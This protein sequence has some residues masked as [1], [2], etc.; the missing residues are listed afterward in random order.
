LRRV[1]RRNLAALSP[2]PLLGKSIRFWK[3][4]NIADVE[5]ALAIDRFLHT[6]VIVRLES[7]DAL[8][9]L[10]DVEGPRH[11]ILKS[12]YVPEGKAIMMRTYKIEQPPIFR[13]TYDDLSNYRKND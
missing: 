5:E 6:T 10:I 8:V 3:L 12:P 2:I 7:F 13:I 4:I 1:R 9:A 11:K